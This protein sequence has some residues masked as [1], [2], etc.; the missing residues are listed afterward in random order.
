MKKSNLP[1][2]WVRWHRH[3]YRSLIA[4]GLGAVAWDVA[5][6]EAKARHR[7]ARIIGNTRAREARLACIGRS[8]R[9]RFALTGDIANLSDE[10][11]SALEELSLAVADL[12]A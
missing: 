2:S 12:P 5:K 10:Q 7:I 4:Q 3:R 8:T 9:L 1:I 6:G 11:V